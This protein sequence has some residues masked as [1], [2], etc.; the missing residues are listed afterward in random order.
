MIDQGIA[1]LAFDM[2]NLVI[3]QVT[4]ADLLALEWDGKFI[5]YRRLYARLYHR[6]LLGTSLMWVVECLQ[7][8]I[9][10]QA[11]VMLKSGERDAA[12]GNTCAYIFSFRVKPEWRNRGIGNRLMLF[13]EDDL[14][15]RGFKFVTL[16]VAKD[17]PDALRLYQ[18][19]GYLVTGSRPGVWTYTDH[20][21]RTC[22][23]NEPAWRMMKRLRSE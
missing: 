21:G 22:H 17:N 11:F 6:T 14:Q 2:P 18:R 7:G 9:I 5:K 20:E 19:L 13:V 15:Q 16:N 8:E 4:K 10:G 12:D 3:R 1:P 23:V